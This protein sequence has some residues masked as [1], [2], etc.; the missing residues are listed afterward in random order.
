MLPDTS[1][2][3]QRVQLLLVKANHFW[4]DMHFI[5]TIYHTPSAQC[6]TTN[7]ESLQCIRYVSKSITHGGC[8]EAAVR[9]R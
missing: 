9:K 1:A 8:M 4:L 6:R 2:Y 5:L 3:G 7:L